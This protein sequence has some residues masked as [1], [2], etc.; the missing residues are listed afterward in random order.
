MSTRETTRRAPPGPDVDAEEE[1]DLGRYWNTIVAR[2]WLPLLG[3]I[4]G[5]AIGYLLALGGGGGY[6]AESTA[7][8][9][10]PFSPTRDVAVQ[11]PNTS[12]RTGNVLVP[13]QATDSQA[14][15][16]GG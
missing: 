14:A 2:W 16:E 8:L 3:L 6:V 15:S 11:S 1:V 10:V 4:G 5:A 7:D 13:S 9:G 12:P